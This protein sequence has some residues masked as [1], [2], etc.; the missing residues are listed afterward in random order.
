MAVDELWTIAAVDI[1]GTVIGQITDQQVSPD[2]QE[3]LTGDSG[4]VYNRAASILAESPRIT[5]TTECV[6]TLLATV[7]LTGLALTTEVPVTVYFQP[8]AA[9]GTRTAAGC[10]GWKV[11]AGLMV[12]RSISA[13]RGQLASVTV[14][15]IPVSDGTN[16][17]IE[18][19]SSQTHPTLPT[20]TQ[21]IA[22]G[23]AVQSLE[24]DS[25]IE[26]TTMG[27]GALAWPTFAAIER[28]QPSVRIVKS[29]MG[30]LT[31]G[32][33][34]S[35]A[36]QLLSLGGFK[37]SAPI[38]FTFNQELVTTR[39]IGGR[40]AMTEYNVT[41]TYDATNAPIVITGVT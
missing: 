21:Y 12:W 8:Y 26:V 5:F 3:S 34:G 31:V 25:G 15:I 6:K 27:D 29:S 13:S 24:I 39:S 35:V 32:S 33:E 38:T 18:K 41:P 30:E 28:V 36:L 11:A 16:H 22:D 19:L 4:G 37:G 2:I 10:V 17:P 40:P 7:G 14:E 23:T 9:G 1:D 20:P